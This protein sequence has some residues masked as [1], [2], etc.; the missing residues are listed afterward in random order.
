MN[1]SWSRYCIPESTK[2]S[3]QGFTLFEMLIAMALTAVI[4]TVLFRTW[5]MV[6][7][8]GR[9]AQQVVAGRERGR[10]V[11]G[12]IDN[13]IAAI[14]TTS[15]GLTTLP[16][17][18]KTAILSSEEYYTQTET[19][20]PEAEEGEEILLSFATGMSAFPEAVSAGDMVC[21]EYRLRSG[22]SGKKMLVRRERAFCGVSG[23]FPWR[24]IVLFSSLVT[25]RFDLV[26]P[27]DQIITEWGE[28]GTDVAE[29]TGIVGLRLTYKMADG[30]E[31]DYFYSY[32]MTRRTDIG[33]E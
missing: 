8:S 21:V 22:L 27:D 26:L 10:I 2:P 15:E 28:D 31:E 9:Y 12:I 25:A 17:L 20:P 14:H 4:G 24:E 1:C 13:D 3:P 7:M 32:M 11:F 30:E 33:W 29:D 6:A 23:E 19:E 5:D 18:G 16:L